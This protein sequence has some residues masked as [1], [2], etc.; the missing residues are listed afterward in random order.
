MTALKPGVYTAL[1]TLT[2]GKTSRT[3]NLVDYKGMKELIDHQAD[4]GVE[5]ILLLGTTGQSPTILGD[6]RKRVIT[7]LV[8]HTR[9]KGMI[10]VV[11]CGSN[12]TK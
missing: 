3:N 8:Q 2:K 4:A 11:G 5:G 6:S 12:A 1:V 7:E 9:E 10:P